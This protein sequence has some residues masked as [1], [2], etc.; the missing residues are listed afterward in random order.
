MVDEIREVF[1]GEAREI[2]STLE[3]D[4]VNLEE[5]NDDTSLI[6]EIFRNIHTMKGS[7]GIVGF[8]QIY[9]FTHVL[10]NLFEDVRA[11]RLNVSKELIDLMLDSVDWVKFVIF[12]EGEDDEKIA[13]LEESLRDRLKVFKEV[14]NINS[15][16]PEK[17]IEKNKETKI[18]TERYY[19]VVA[20]FI[21]ETFQ[22]GVDPL[23][24]IE[25][26]YVVGELIS[27][28]VIK[29]NVPEFEDYD[30]ELC[31]L[32]W[33]IIIKTD[34]GKEDIENV[35]LFVS[36][37]NIVI[38]DVSDN[39]KNITNV[40]DN[41]EKMVGEILVEKGIISEN[42]LDSIVE[43]QEEQQIKLGDIA[44]K[45]G[46]ASE[47]DI[48]DALSEQQNLRQKLSETTIRV[49]TG[50]LDKLLNL[51]G[52]IV[53]GQSSLTRI[54]D[55]LDEKVAERLKNAMYGLERTTRE[56]QGQIMGIR[57][58]PIGPT[59]E[60]FKRFVRDA[61]KENKKEIKLLIEGGETELDKTVIEKIGDPLKHMIRNSIDHG[62]EYP[63][64]RVKNG[65]D[66]VGMITLKSYHQEGNVYVE[67]NDDGGGI[68][69]E[70]IKEKAISQGL[71]REDEE[72]P[73]DQLLMFIFHPGFSTADKVGDLSG[74]GVG[75]DVVKTNIEA[76]RGSIQVS[77]EEG[78]GSTI[79]IKLPLTLAIIDGMLVN[80]GESIFIV[81]LLS[82]V[83]S[84][85]PKEGD[86]KTVEGKGEMILVRGEYIP[87]VR[88]YELFDLVPYHK[89]PCEA[90]VVIAESNNNRVA[91]L[92]DDLIGQQQIVIKSI[93]Q[94]ISNSR[95]VSGASILGDG[96]VALI[97][98]IHGLL[99]DL[100][101]YR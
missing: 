52:E 78:Q 24:L 94:Y 6:N 75:M 2:I 60:Q 80:I 23:S 13:N 46:L 61:A 70:K 20:N 93:D 64:E 35:F 77:S 88:L 19:R 98:D 86:I 26:L 54:A 22:Y 32:G 30:P 1:I 10:E 48:S 33:D 4:L 56:F 40:V 101:A 82:V 68:K 67:I 9:E 11:S 91:M 29:N 42:D 76:L 5:N 81:P 84:I 72:I 99:E 59:F 55:E 31:Y 28:K 7:S 85:Q 63:D 14:E 73:R 38:S 92:I 87:F 3:N 18:Q 17:E 74:R 41:S 57:M 25:D 53:I 89:N 69:Y 12:S 100:S 65:K 47:N 27:R 83:E 95:S 45:K 49:D 71:L 62:I 37:Q 44:V 34:G 51:L 43:L 8:N 21:P 79:K 15:K 90:L 16:Q 58:I 39:F 50:R 96:K 36:D 97:L 66:K